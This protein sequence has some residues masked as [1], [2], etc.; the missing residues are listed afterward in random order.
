MELWEFKVFL[1][2]TSYKKTLISTVS[3]APLHFGTH[4]LSEFLKGFFFL[5]QFHFNDK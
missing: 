4:Y 1:D 2:Y 3:T 5:K